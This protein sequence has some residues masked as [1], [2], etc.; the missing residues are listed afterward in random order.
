MTD[1]REPP[2]AAPLADAKRSLACCM[3]AL[4]AAVHLQPALGQQLGSVH[5]A[6]ADALTELQRLEQR[7]AA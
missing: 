4:R 7:S 6:L 5:A 1:P 3:T 2:E